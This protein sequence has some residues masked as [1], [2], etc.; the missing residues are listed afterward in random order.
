[1]ADF[2]DFLTGA[3]YGAGAGASFG[4]W[5]L[6]AGGIGGGLIG[7]LGKKNEP[8]KTP[9]Y[10]N[11]YESQI[12]YGIERQM[13][14]HLGRD[15]AGVS[16]GILR[17]QASDAFESLQANPAFSDNPAEA[18][19][20]YNKL[21]REAG[22]GIQSAYLEGSRIDE[23]TQAQGLQ[24]ASEQSRLKQQDFQFRTQMD[25][26]N[27]ANEGP[28]ALEQLLY[29]A[30]SYGLGSVI[31]GAGGAPKPTEAAP[32]TPEQTM[33]TAIESGGLRS[34]NRNRDFRTLSST[35]MPGG[36]ALAMPGQANLS[37]GFQYPQNNLL[38]PQGAG[39]DASS[40]YGRNRTLSQLLM[41]R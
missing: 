14:S 27:K 21:Q 12:N 10:T 38:S 39:I 28:S 33:N 19:E 15:Q 17:N 7:L 18:S 13:N 36:P 34:P 30:G 3:T 24:A 32:P 37:R 31:A 22:K 23:A 29:T 26:A 1:M 4:P 2:N 8:E 5:G 6:I 35:S 25:A 16:A 9:E 40:F 20:A 11:P 41:G